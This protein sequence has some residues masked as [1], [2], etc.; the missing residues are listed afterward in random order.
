M[1]GSHLFLVDVPR[2]PFDAS[3]PLGYNAE[4]GTLHTVGI[5]GAFDGKIR[6][7]H[8]RYGDSRTPDYRYISRLDGRPM[9]IPLKSER[10]K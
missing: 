3:K 6:D 5:E 1:V 9:D 8:K 2:D 10:A 4:Q 7:P